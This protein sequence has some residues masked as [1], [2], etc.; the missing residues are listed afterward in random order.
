VTAFL[1]IACENE[2]LFQEMARN[3]ARDIASGKAMSACARFLMRCSY[4]I[5]PGRNIARKEMQLRE[6]GVL[7]FLTA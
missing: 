4:L 6:V 1:S 3:A 5:E 2:R 7:M